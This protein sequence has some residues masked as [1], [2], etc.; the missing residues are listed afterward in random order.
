MYRRNFLVRTGM[1]VGTAALSS[2]GKNTE[3]LLAAE[4]QTTPLSWDEVRKAF[5]LAPDR[6]HMSAFFLASHPKPVRE[7]IEEHRRAFDRSPLEYF[8]ANESKREAAVLAAAAHRLGADPGEIAL[9]DSTTMGLGLL[10][11]GLHLRPDQEIL[12]TTHDHYATETALRL[13]AERTGA[14]LRRISLYQEGQPT[15]VSQIVETLSRAVRPQT[16]VVALTWVH[17]GTGVKLPLRAMA[18]ALG[19]LNTSRDEPDR[20]LLCVDGVHGLGIEAV[21]LPELGCD[22]FIAGTHNWIFGP[23]GTGLVWG[24][25]AAWKAATATIPTFDEETYLQWMGVRP[26]AAVPVGPTMTPGGFHSFEH[27]WALDK[28]FL[29]HEQIGRQRIAGRLHSQ[30]RQLKEGLAKMAKV[31]LYTPLSDELS[32][33]I[34]YFDVNGLRAQEVVERL[35]RKNIVAS[36]TPYK[37][38]YVRLAPSLVTSPQ[39]VDTTLA[40]VREIAA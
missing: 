34:V 28:A 7:A 29:W 27:R 3:T 17:S 31:K 15:S 36:V 16:R 20:V 18:D 30:N 39:E 1:L 12:I 5:N 22:F 35:R 14:S 19:R 38:L 2:A 25:P 23:R 26:P 37:T 6:I 8:F 9:T 4:A 33:G 10:Y 21:T 11:S 40:A 32:A 13:R 24:T